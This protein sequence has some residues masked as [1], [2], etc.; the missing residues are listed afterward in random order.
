[1]EIK[2]AWYATL[3][4]CCYPREAHHSPQNQDDNKFIALSGPLMMCNAARVTS[5]TSGSRSAEKSEKL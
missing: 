5:A 4:V 2:Q 1:M 3:S